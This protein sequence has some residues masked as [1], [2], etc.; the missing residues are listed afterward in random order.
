MITLLETPCGQTAAAPARNPANPAQ[1][2]LVVEDDAGLRQLNSH[3]LARSGYQVDA[4]EDGI[5]GWAAL[6]AQTF[7]LLITDHDLPRLSGL[8]LVKRVRLAR[9]PLPIV[10]ASGALP[11]EELAQHP[12]LQIAATLLKPFSPVQLLETVRTALRALTP[13]SI[14]ADNGFPLR[15][16]AEPVRSIEPLPPSPG[17]P[18][19]NDPYWR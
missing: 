2:I 4:A 6:R 17:Q 15:V 7:D 19:M 14:G 11:T 13:A 9:M 8:D 12:W 16:L 18:P 1:R 5:A 10:L 3:V